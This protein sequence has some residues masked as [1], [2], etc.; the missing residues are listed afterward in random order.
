MTGRERA[1]EA[2]DAMERSLTRT[3]PARYPRIHAHDRVR[4]Y[5]VAWNRAL[6][7]WEAAD[8]PEA[9]QR[10]WV[11][12]NAW[13]SAWRRAVEAWRQ[14]GCTT[15]EAME[16][17]YLRDERLGMITDAQDTRARIDMEAS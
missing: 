3:L 17:A 10:V 14:E 16:A 1:Q 15:E 13:I 11:A 5:R 7:G 2:A 4:H 6:A 12:G 8:T 9:R